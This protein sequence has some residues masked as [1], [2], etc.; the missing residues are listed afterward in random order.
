MGNT[1]F[2]SVWLWR[3]CHTNLEG[4][5]R[6]S[7]PSSR[8]SAELWLSLSGPR[9]CPSRPSNPGGGV[10]TQGVL[11]EGTAF[12]SRRWSLLRVHNACRE[13][14]ST[15]VFLLV[16]RWLLLCSRSCILPARGRGL[17]SEA[18]KA[19]A[20]REQG[21]AWCSLGQIPQ[22]TSSHFILTRVR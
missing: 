8:R 19:W 22:L 3:C 16:F 14:R 15:S 12:A 4:R 10:L 6:M 11:Q 17:V 9:L 18:A 5:G 21:G 13:T 2:P 7:W 20:P 1:R